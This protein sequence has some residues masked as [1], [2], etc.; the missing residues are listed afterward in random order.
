MSDAP[1]PIVLELDR[2]LAAPP[3]RVFRAWTEPA[4]LVRWFCPN[5]DLPTTAEVD[6]RVGGAYRIRMGTHEVSGAYRTVDPPRALAFTWGWATD[7]EPARMLVTV[8]FEPLDGGGTRLRLRHERFA[9]EDERANHASGW[10][11]SLARLPGAL[12]GSGDGEA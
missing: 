8:T 9:N 5:P 12:G 1:A 6:L 10:T 4:E 7:A 3:E 11:A 2:A